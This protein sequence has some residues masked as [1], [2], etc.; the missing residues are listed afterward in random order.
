MKLSNLA[1]KRPVTTTMVVLLVV[2][3]GF[4]SFNRTN[5]DLFPDITYPGAAVITSYSGTGPEEVETMVTKPL[6]SSLATVTNIQTLSSTSSKGQSTV[7]A[8]FSWGTDMDTAAMDMRESIDMIRDALPDEVSDPYVIQFDPSMMP[9]MQMG[10][11]SNMDLAELKE[12]IENKVSPNLE[13]LE[14]VAAVNLVGGKEREIL[15]EVNENKLNNYNVSFD[16][17]RN[18]LMANN[19]NMSGG[20]VRRGDIEYLVRVTGKFE[21][22]NEIKEVKIAT[23]SGGIVSLD[24]LATVTD[25]YKEM[26]TKSKLNGQPSIGLT[27]QKAT[28]ANTVAVSNR[29]KEEINKLQN[30]YDSN[31]LQLLPIMDQADYI[32]QSVGNVGR[33]AIYGAILAVLVLWFFLRNIRSTIIIATAIP[34]SVITTFMLLYFGNLTLN[35]MTLGGLALG[36]GMLVD[37]SIVVLENIYRYRKEGLSKLEAA[38][39]GSNEVGMAIAASTITTAI[40]FLPVVFV[41][42]MASQIFQELAI[43]VAFALLASLLVSLTLIPV[44]ASKILK[45]NKKDEKTNK[46][47][48]KL[49]ESYTNS[50][51]WAIDHHW[52]V[53]IVVVVVFAGSLFLFP[54]IGQEFIP[55]MDQ[56]Q[57]T[58]TANMPVGTP[59]ETT[60]ETATKIEETVLDIPEVDT[61]L[62]NIGSTGQMMGGSQSGSEI[63]SISV[64]LVDLGDR[65]R[66]TQEVMEEVRKKINI[67]GVELN[68]AA[69]DMMGGGGLSGGKPVVI[70]ILGND[71]NILENI[72][73]SI[74][75]EIN[76]INGIRG[77]EDSISEGRPEMQVKVN[78][79]LAA[80]Y[81]LS[82]AQI[83]STIET[84]ISGNT[85]TRYEVGGEEYDVR[86]TLP[87]DNINSPED[88]KN[89]TLTSPQG[90]KV[91][92]SSI[93]DFKIETG[94]RSITRENQQRYVTV[95]A[96]LFQRDLGDTMDEI[97]NKLDKNLTL[98]AGYNIEYG[99][100][101]Q[102]MV[103]AFGDL[104]FAFILA[105][106]LVYMV[107]ASQ[108]E[109]LVDPFIIMF[110]V[111]MA[112]IGVLFGL[113]ITGYTLS[114]VSIIGLVM[115]S[116]IVVNNA[117]V[118]VDYIN[119]VRLRGKGMKEAIIEAAPVR[120]RPVLMTALTTILALLPI[121]L[122]FGEGAEIQAPMAVVVISGLIVATFLTLY[123]VPVLYAIFEKYAK[124]IK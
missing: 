58:I 56:G 97:R 108:F 77:V 110:T 78:R 91:K 94:P 99:G 19:L 38:H 13:R 89:M 53:L 87:D 50:L 67:P 43:T 8:E 102:E 62:T 119:T 40:V 106:V 116:G 21:S 25:T 96:D 42:G 16:S 52:L 124:K 64:N 104:G 103:N 9:I 90:S 112:I 86:V 60:E 44:M 118:L 85:A 36:V 48:E 120:L 114:V 5:L 83:G 54:A 35:L 33:N 23:G 39:K 29:V 4:I 72:A 88:V 81:G 27:V 31:G 75:R 22:I 41:G 73:Q 101:Y 24:E 30:N 115:L 26:T 61:M 49:K 95:S 76:N 57:F 105:I 92:L 11:T 66:S 15:V 45:I 3:L 84:S 79:N 71:L 55:G 65:E 74:K 34:V 28:D 18:S 123:I 1:I 107:M 12:L 111:P 109:S 14:G 82:I 59:L 10:V 117:I 100:E 20:S 37:N 32:E 70:R 122:G 80:N 68:I 113:F 69:Q 51:S 93:A 6:E 46:W 7:V 2:L 121:A 63:A 98:P 17:I 47:F